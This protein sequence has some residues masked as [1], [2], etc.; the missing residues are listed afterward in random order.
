MGFFD[1]IRKGKLYFGKKEPLV[2]VQFLFGG[3]TYILEEF[4]MNFRQDTNE[5][6]QPDSDI[7]GGLISLTFGETPDENINRWMMNT[8]ERQD[9]EFRFLINT[10]KLM[11]GAALHILF[12]N[13]YCINY[14]KVIIPNGAGLLTTL[15][16]SP[17]FIRIGNEEF[18]NDRKS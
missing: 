18:D 6:N 16:I 14:R 5:K 17:G 8:Y 7:Y 12:K 13:A 4:D 15:T 10:V 2:V 3:K 11:E 1:R 9:G